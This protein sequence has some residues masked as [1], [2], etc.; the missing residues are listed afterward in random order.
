MAPTENR[1]DG[2]TANHQGGIGQVRLIGATSAL[3]PAAAVAAMS[4]KETA[5]AAAAAQPSTRVTVVG[6]AGARD[7][8]GGPSGPPATVILKT[9]VP[10]CPAS[11][12][13]RRPRRPGH[14]EQHLPCLRRLS[15]LSRGDLGADDHVVS[16]ITNDVTVATGRTGPRRALVR[17]AALRRFPLPKGQGTA[18]QCPAPAMA[19]RRANGA[20]PSAAE[21]AAPVLPDMLVASVVTAQ[22]YATA[23]SVDKQ[24]ALRRPG[25]EACAGLQVS[26]A[27]RRADLSS[28]L[29]RHRRH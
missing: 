24:G 18:W 3:G 20:V 15:L 17:P 23:G 8:A 21:P 22:P 26:G 13:R 29:A 11:P 28:C 16:F 1:S 9:A 27:R 14:G 19:A 4:T 12:H 10:L 6:S 5:M 25:S 2:F 7:P